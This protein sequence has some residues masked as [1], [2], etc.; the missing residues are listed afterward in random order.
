MQ[1]A[2]KL[3]GINESNQTILSITLNRLND[4]FKFWKNIHATKM[5]IQ[6]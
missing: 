4:G 5:R 2:W 1:A 6:L 3:V